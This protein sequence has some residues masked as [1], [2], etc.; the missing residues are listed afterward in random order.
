MLRERS[1]DPCDMGNHCA[2]CITFALFPPF[3]PTTTRETALAGN[4]SFS[5]LLARPE[6]FSAL[7]WTPP[8]ILLYGC[9]VVKEYTVGIF[10]FMSHLFVTVLCCD[11]VS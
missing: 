9:I 10:H 6:A 3:D 8:V 4:D 1:R 5:F 7:A 11:L 2:Y